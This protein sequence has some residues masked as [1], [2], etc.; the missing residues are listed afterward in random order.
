VNIFPLAMCGR[1]TLTVN[2]EALEKRFG[3]TFYSEDLERYNP[4]PSFNIA[5]THFLPVVSM[6]DTEHFSWMRWGLI[7]TWA[8][9]ASI[10]SKMINARIETLQEKS[11]FKRPF[12][13]RRCIIPLDGYYEWMKSGKKRIPY[14]I[15]VGEGEVFAVAGISDIWRMP[16][17]DH[18]T[19]FSIITQQAPSEIAH[20]HDRMPA[21]LDQASERE[22]LSDELPASDLLRLPS[23]FESSRLNYYRVSE[24]VNKAAVNHADLIIE[25]ED[26]PVD[27]DDGLQLKLF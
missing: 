2:E 15:I 3:S 1:S 22:W 5:P 6:A 20:I 17:G 16:S 8:K 11:A 23:L 18:L 26:P 27:F 9:D 12:A 19:T 25:V 24:E 10:A 21:I 7:P 13:S 14:R 4:L